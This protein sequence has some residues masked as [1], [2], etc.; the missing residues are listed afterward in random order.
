MQGVLP[1]TAEVLHE[2]STLDCFKDYLLIG[3]TA[4]SLQ[5]NHR[6]SE[7]I[8]FCRWKTTKFDQPEVNIKQVE[9]ELSSIGSFQRNILD[10]NH[11]DYV[12]KDI[13]ITFFCNN[14]YKKPVNLQPIPFLNNIKLADL[15]SIGMMKLEAMLYRSLFR[16]YYDF[17]S[18]IQS[19]GNFNNIIDDFLKYSNHDFRCRDILSMIADGKRFS[20]KQNIAH[21]LPRYLVTPDEIGTFL[22]PY[23]SNYNDLKVLRKAKM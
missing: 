8:D 13:K 22:L 19:G 12:F 16:D 7:D 18:I 15:N 2:I 5:I 23:I 20:Y 3:G 11:V 1:E 17:F 9:K 14:R 10:K 4:L 21:L 6:L